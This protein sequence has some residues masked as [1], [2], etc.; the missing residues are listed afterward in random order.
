MEIIKRKLPVFF[1]IL[2]LALSIIAIMPAALLAQEEETSEEE[3]IPEPEPEELSFET[4]LPKI[5]AEEGETFNFDFTVIYKAGDEPFGLDEN[6][7][8]K[9][10]DIT[11]D[12]PTGWIAAVAK[13]TTEARTINLESGSTE[14]L[15]LVAAPRTSQ[16][17][18]EYNFTVTF[19]SAIEG[20]PLEESMEFTAVIT[21]TYEISLTTKTGRLSTDITSGKDNHY[22]LVLANNSS[23]SVENIS[24]T[25]TEPEGW[26]VDFD[27]KEIDIIEAGEE[28]EIDVVIN[29]PEKTIAGD[30]ILTFKASSENSNDE[31]ELRVT[32]ETSTIWGIVG[33]GIIVI[34][35]VGVAIIFTRL[36]RR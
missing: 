7:K 10:F 6:T 8:T 9:P 16:E 23:T 24:L 19:K 27:N 35:I 30:Y 29:P 14:S 5:Q 17:P 13:G 33:I 11:V 2:T 21:A 34:V 20:D 1:I 28:K 3:F 15:K 4:T 12:Y 22:K 25:S 26:Q 18:G 32:V 31:I 36:G